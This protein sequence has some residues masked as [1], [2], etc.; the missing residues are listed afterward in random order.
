MAAWAACPAPHLSRAEQRGRGS[1]AAAQPCPRAS[2]A[3]LCATPRPCPPVPACSPP[4]PRH[5]S[6]RRFVALS[7]SC[8]LCVVAL[9]PPASGSPTG[10]RQQRATWRAGALTR[11][12]TSTMAA[13]ASGL[14]RAP[15][16]YSRGRQRSAA[17]CNAGQRSAGAAAP[18]LRMEQ[19]QRCSHPFLLASTAPTITPPPPPPRG[20]L[21]RPTLILD[22][23]R[24]L[25]R[26]SSQQH[27]SPPP[28]P[29]RTSPASLSPL[30]IPT[31]TPT[32]TPALPTIP[33][34]A[35]AHSS[36]SSPMGRRRGQ[37]RKRCRS[38]SPSPLSP[39]PAA[40]D[41][42]P[43]RQAHPAVQLRA[44]RQRAYG[45][46]VRRKCRRRR[47]RRQRAEVGS[48]RAEVG[49]QRAEVGCWRCLARRRQA[50]AA[51]TQRRT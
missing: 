30:P 36:S 38:P 17:V 4:C 48:Q 5:R 23:I 46:A 22:G 20:L 15:A 19:R 32:P 27:P 44:G 31:L 2:A 29:T 11:R 51:V 7:A 34:S 45:V 6:A 50:E 33:P 18:R 39:S 1:S 43:H 9:H 3:P 47:H 26:P 28:P 37:Q 40:D 25:R 12:G 41:G 21:P 14:R 24:S 49:C 42:P 10:T 35:L 16:L 8:P 13:A